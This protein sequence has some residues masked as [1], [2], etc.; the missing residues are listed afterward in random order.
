MGRPAIVRAAS[1]D[2]EAVAGIEKSA[3]AAPWRAE[4]FLRELTNPDGIFLVAKMEGKVIGYALAW[5]IVDEAHIVNVAVDAGHRKQGHG[6]SLVERL[7]EESKKRGATCA[8]LE[9]RDGN[10]DAVELYRRLGF[11]EAGLRKGYYHGVADA[12][13]MWLHEMPK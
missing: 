5:I 9:V 11:V 12:V 3:H 2:V 13:I 4:S 10:T 6:R 7:L 8:T 1:E